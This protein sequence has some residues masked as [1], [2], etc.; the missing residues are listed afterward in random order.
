MHPLISWNRFALPSLSHV[1]RIRLRTMLKI[2]TSSLGTWE[3]RFG[4]WHLL[5]TLRLPVSPNQITGVKPRSPCISTLTPNSEEV[6]SP[7]KK[8]YHATALRLLP[9]PSPV[10]KKTLWINSINIL[11]KV[12]SP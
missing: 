3:R 7:N 9:H 2:K 12:F 1:E 8:K 11:Q 4:V 10:G 5:L 6:T